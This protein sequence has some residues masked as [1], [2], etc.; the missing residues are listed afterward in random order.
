[1]NMI[2][3]SHHFFRIFM[4]LQ[5]PY[6][7]KLVRCFERHEFYKEVQHS[8]REFVILGVWNLY[9]SII[10]CLLMKEII[11]PSIG[12]RDCR[13]LRSHD[14]SNGTKAQFP[15]NCDGTKL[16]STM[17]MEPAGP[18]KRLNLENKR[19]VSDHVSRML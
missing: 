15:V 11:L 12:L 2:G 5:I 18:T 9:Q 17:R 10:N 13:S 14:G 7:R 1:M 19:L 8:K 16:P 4:S 3:P 6:N